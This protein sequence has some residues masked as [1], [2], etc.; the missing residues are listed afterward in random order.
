MKNKV[1]VFLL[2]LSVA[3]S[4]GGP[5]FA[6]VTIMAGADL[7]GSWELSGDMED[8]GDTEMGYF[9][10]GEF[11]TSISPLVS[12]GGGLRYQLERADSDADDF[13]WNFIPIYALAHL[14]FPAAM[15]DFFVAGQLGYNIFQISDDASD[16]LGDPDVSGG[17]Y[18][19]IGGGLKLPMGL[20]FE[21]LYCINNGSVENDGYEADIAASQLSL[22]VGL[23]F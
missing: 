8:D 9:L 10:G 15:A 21:L 12:V 1:L 4:F 17:L 11:S 19:G 23:C 3:A 2:A 16:L 20:Q 22:S 14:N 18:Y 13:G 5:L 6:D 7:L